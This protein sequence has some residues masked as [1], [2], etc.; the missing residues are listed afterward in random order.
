M[1]RWVGETLRK[2]FVSSAVLDC[3]EEYVRRVFE[4]PINLTGF[5]P[6]QFWEKGVLDALS[7]LSCSGHASSGSLECVDI[8]SGSGLPGMVLAII[9]SEWEWTLVESRVRR[10][11]FLLNTAA[12][13]GLSNVKVVGERAE[14]WV[15]QNPMIREHFD[16]VT[17]RAV[18]PMLTTAELALPLAKIGGTIALPMGLEG[19]KGLVAS[20]IISVLGGEVNEEGGD[21]LLSG[22]GIIRKMRS[23]PAVFPRIGSKLGKF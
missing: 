1:D 4:S 11:E 5:S 2:A 15:C 23:T 14:V 18:G 7:L 6:A 20:P 3:L 16:L 19:V 12:S 10:A 22:I 8:G 9:R 21:G 17:A 13:L